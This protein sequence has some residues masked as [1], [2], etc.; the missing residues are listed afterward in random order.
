MKRIPKTEV[1]ILGT[2]ASQLGLKR[3]PLATSTLPQE[4]NVIDSETP[5]QQGTFK[6]EG[7]L[8]ENKRD[9]SLK[10]LLTDD[11]KQREKRKNEDDKRVEEDHY[12]QSKGRVQPQSTHLPTGK[13]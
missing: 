11:S 8:G 12:L 2:V 13:Q 6:E 9:V 1:Q 3:N 4:G 10:E 7:S 5:L